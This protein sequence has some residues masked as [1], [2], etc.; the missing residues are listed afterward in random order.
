MARWF[1]RSFCGVCFVWLAL[2]VGRTAWAEVESGPAVGA[3]IPELKVQT[4]TG[5]LADHEADQA[6]DR[7]GKPTIYLL[8]D[9]AAFDRPMARFMKALDK[10]ASDAGETA[11]V[12]AVWLTDDAKASEAYLPR[13]Q[14]SLKFENTSLCVYRGDKGGPGPWSIHAKARITVVVSGGKT[15]AARFGFVSVNE[16]DAADVLSAWKKGLEVK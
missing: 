2:A 13:A 7:Q 1:A 4:V 9:A 10:K 12:V 14:Q 15:V 6:A 16:T 11:R 8:V 5:P 3:K